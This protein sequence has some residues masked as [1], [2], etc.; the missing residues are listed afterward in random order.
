MKL[1]SVKLR[2]HGGHFSGPSHFWLQSMGG[3][4]DLRKFFLLC[5]VLFTAESNK[6]RW[7]RNELMSFGSVMKVN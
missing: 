3:K 1:I 4:F 5:A 2:S 6:V 7:L